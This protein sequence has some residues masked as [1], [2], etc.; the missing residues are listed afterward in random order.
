MIELD[1]V[2]HIEIKPN[3]NL[4]MWTDGCGCCA[5]YEYIEDKDVKVLVIKH[6]IKRYQDML[7]AVDAN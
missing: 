7:E 3:G 6:I 5:D 1:K 2:V 4:C